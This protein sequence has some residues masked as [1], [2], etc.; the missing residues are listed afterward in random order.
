MLIRW[1][2]WGLLVVTHKGRSWADSADY[3]T[4]LGNYVYY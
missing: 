1:R 4:G 3:L 2:G